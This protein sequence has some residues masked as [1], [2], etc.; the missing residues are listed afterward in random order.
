[1]HVDA[2]RGCLCC[3]T[4]LVLLTNLLCHGPPF[5]ELNELMA[6]GIDSTDHLAIMARLTHDSAGLFA[7][8]PA[9]IRIQLLEDRDPAG[10]VQVSHIEL[11]E[12]ASMRAAWLLAATVALKRSSM[13][14]LQRSFTA[15]YPSRKAADPPGGG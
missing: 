8:L 15:S 1:M 9:S 12:R 3:F 7:T 14:C 6:T 13:G 5:Q 4:R 11:G 2:E 10:N